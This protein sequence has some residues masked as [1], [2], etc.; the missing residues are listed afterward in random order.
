M[1]N[2][3]SSSRAIAIAPS[4]IDAFAFNHPKIRNLETRAVALNLGNF[5]MA[6][7]RLGAVS[8]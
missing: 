7:R 5:A 4:S 1:P 3:V 2:V 6:L 8:E